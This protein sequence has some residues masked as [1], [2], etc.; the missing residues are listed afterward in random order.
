MV[1]EALEHEGIPYLVKKEVLKSWMVIQGNIEGAEVALYVNQEDFEDADA[2]LN[3][4]V[5]H[6]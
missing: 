4:M 2:I 6:I 3:Q 1:G 5:D